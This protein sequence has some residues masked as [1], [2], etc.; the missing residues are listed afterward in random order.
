MKKVFEVGDEVRVTSTS[1][2]GIAYTNSAGGT[3][4]FPKGTVKEC[5]IIRAWGDYE[6]GRRYVGMTLHQ[7][8]VY[9]GE[10]GVEIEE[11]KRFV[12]KLTQESSSEHLDWEDVEEFGRNQPGEVVL[13]WNCFAVNEEDALDRFHETI[14]ISAV[15]DYSWEAGEVEEVKA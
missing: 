3:S 1:D 11:M 4:E 5:L 14:P 12:V 7:K 8:E 2:F 9:F 10:F 15:E 6:I 13:E